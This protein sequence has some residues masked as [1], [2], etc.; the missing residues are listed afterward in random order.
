METATKT[1]VVIVGGG[2]TGLSLACQLVRYGVDFVLIE[3]NEGVTHFSKALGVHA[4]TLEIYEQLGMAKEAVE[5]GAVAGKFRLLEGGEVR[6]EIP[7]S[8]IGQNLSPYPFML[9]LEQSKN[10]QLLYEYLES[11][12]KGVLWSTEL[13]SFTQDEM[14][15]TVKIKGAGGEAKTI[16]AKYLV[17]CDGAKSPVRHALKL[18]FEGSTFERLFYV[19]DA[20]IDWDL[21]HDAVQVCLARE[22]FTAFFPMKG[23]KRYRIVGTF[24]EGVDKEEGEVVYEEIEQQIK[25]EA[26]LKLEI[27]EVNW[28]S[29]YKVHTRRVNK[30]SEGRCFV[31]GD[32]AH[33]HSPAGAQGMNTG[34]QDAYNL[35]WKLALV[36]KG[37]A[38]E[39]LLESY[40]EERLENAK[41]LL[42][43]TDRMFELG[44]GAGWLVSLIRTTIF[45]PL[46]GYLVSFDVVKK[47]IFPLLS[48][49]GINYR[50][51]RLSDHAGDD[52]FEVK[53]GDR[54]PY[55]L[56]DGQSV[57]DLLHA[58]KFNLLIFQTPGTDYRE[59]NS[60]VER[61]YPGLVDCQLVP[62]SPRVE[63]VFGA[64]E[65]FCV[66]LRPDNYIGF[67]SAEVSAGKVRD[68]LSGFAR[69]S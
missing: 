24:P 19:A 33:I 21:P 2:P 63:E 35:A 59:I 55:F 42:E 23:D 37:E 20:Q 62:L 25:D 51:C 47:L 29:L 9:I 13:E 65:P 10:E 66:L 41:R 30:F 31:A 7:F 26:K 56:I 54:M 40:N 16:R 53:A 64:K 34:I 68:Y 57:Y 17:G 38:G 67:I 44:A 39:K 1:D 18:A 45:P 48:Q 27:S 69:L 52:D 43:T 60:E 58:P 36:I 15:V 11:H 49:I 6:G 22:V 8:D 61:A 3:K 14:G 4:R 5:R 12:G 50:D 32:A 46:A 28:F